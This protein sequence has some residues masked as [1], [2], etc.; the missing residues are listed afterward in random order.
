MREKKANGEVTYGKEETSHLNCWTKSGGER[1]NEGKIKRKKEKRE[2]K[3]RS[4]K[5]H[6]L[7]R[8]YGN[9]TV[10]FRRGKRQSST[11]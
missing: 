6:L 1:K 10:Y 8:F 9:Q 7:S 5:L 3:K 11:T 4:E 2:E